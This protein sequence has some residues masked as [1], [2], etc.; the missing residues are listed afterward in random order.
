M[1]AEPQ[2]PHYINDE[3]KKRRNAQ[4]QVAKQ[5]RQRCHRQGTLREYGYHLCLLSQL[6]RTSS[7]VVRM[8]FLRMIVTA[9][10][11]DRSARSVVWWDAARKPGSTCIRLLRD[12]QAL[13]LL[14]K[15][16]PEAF[17][18]KLDVGHKRRFRK[19]LHLLGARPV[20]LSYKSISQS[21]I[22]PVHSA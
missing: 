15:P 8:E 14:A 9:K 3:R 18:T 4:Y 1:Q 10:R 7:R 20:C 13:R 6:G 17:D 2:E 11:G 5:A 21:K 22:S 12:K 16:L 19:L